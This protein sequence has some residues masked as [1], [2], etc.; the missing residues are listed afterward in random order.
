MYVI[1]SAIILIFLQFLSTPLAMA[2]K[3]ADVIKL[4]APVDTPMKLLLG[5]NSDTGQLVEQCVDAVSFKT[6]PG[7]DPSSRADFRFVHSMQEV[8]QEE[9]LDVSAKMSIQVPLAG[10]SAG[11]DIKQFKS[12]QSR[13]E[14]G[15]LYGTY[16]DLVK[17]KFLSPNV[18]VVFNQTGADV[19]T[20]SRKRGN[21]KFFRK[22]CGDSVV[23]GFQKDRYI[24]VFGSLE[25]SS[26][27]S[28]SEKEVD[29]KLA[30]RYLMSTFSSKVRMEKSEKKD[31][32]QLK[33]SISYEASGNT[34]TE[35]A[36]NLKKL[37][38][39]WEEFSAQNLSD[40]LTTSYFYIVQY[41]DLLSKDDFGIG[42]SRKELRKIEKIANGLFA[43]D[44]ARGEARR[45]A[46][47][48]TSD[49]ERSRY[50]NTRNRLAKEIKQ[51]RVWLKRNNGCFGKNSDTVVCNNLEKRFS[52]FDNVEKKHN[53]TAFV[54]LAAGPSSLVCAG[55]PVTD[56]SGRT[57]C[58]P[59]G[60]GK[61]P[62]FLR[63]K[64]GRCGYLAKEKKPP[65]ADRL[66]TKDLKT[67]R[68]IQA[69]AG[70]T[71]SVAEYPN[72]CNKKDRKCGQPMAEKVCK[73][74]GYREALG[75]QV[76]NPGALD[77]QSAI[78]R[79]IYPNGKR[80][81]P[82]PDGFDKK[83]CKTFVYVDCLKK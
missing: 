67:V 26:S 12:N 16:R 72:Y 10:G 41:E 1:N 15:M 20:Q 61:Q 8:L 34:K 32:R 24:R 52:N 13:I 74:A 58:R 60:L 27:Q 38:K 46:G 49:S 3:Q 40:T 57:E 47:A 77:V 29:L 4:A 44:Y 5:Y 31:A 19:L 75:Y 7:K 35:G 71:T 73:K 17:P 39:V 25:S 78:A 83:L 69:E 6:S 68:N 45:K 14:N 22:E 70:V 42:V 79:T 76:W 28:Q 48:V 51:V 63:G 80:C 21:P 56:P 9:H 37:K 66:W 11:V 33:V 36:T 82:N 18:A 64:E 54:K 43:L 55:Y 81:K 2:Y 65:N 59:C 50:K 53:M 30:A 62:V 23:I